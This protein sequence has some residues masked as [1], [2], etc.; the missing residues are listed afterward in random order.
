[1]NNSWENLAQQTFGDLLVIGRVDNYKIGKKTGIY[2]L[3][4]CKCGNFSIVVSSTLKN[5]KFHNRCRECNSKA[6]AA[7]GFRKKRLYR[8]WRDM[9]QR[10][11]NKKSTNYKNYGAKGITVC[12]EWLDFVNFKDWALSTG[13]NDTLT[14]ER[15]DNSK[16]YCPENCTWIPMEDQC[17]NR[18]N[19]QLFELNWKRKLLREWAEIYS[20]NYNTVYHRITYQSMSLL[21]ALTTSYVWDHKY[22]GI[23][24][25]K[26]TKKWLLRIRKNNKQHYMGCFSTKEEAYEAKKKIKAELES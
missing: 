2:F 17:K 19:T 6:M 1:M 4:K 5:D 3:C 14:I 10:I 16:G 9:K 7:H 25:H 11:T 13:Y 21:D 15:L 20:K 26:A 23:N 12:E 22:N 24:Y 18:T 8:T